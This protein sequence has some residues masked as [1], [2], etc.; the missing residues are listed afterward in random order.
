M[1]NKWKLRNPLNI[2]SEEFIPKNTII[3][4]FV[5]G[6]DIK[7]HKEKYGAN[8]CRKN[9]CCSASEK[10]KNIHQGYRQQLQPRIQCFAQGLLLAFVIIENFLE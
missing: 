5:E 3:W 4:Q 1:D 10:K 2:E 8:G 6:F 7:V 9:K